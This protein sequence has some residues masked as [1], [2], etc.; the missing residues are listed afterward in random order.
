[1]R[2]NRNGLFLHRTSAT[3]AAD[4]TPDVPTT[5]APARVKF[6]DACRGLAVL[7]ML[8][9]N[10]MN[11]FLRRVPDVLRHNQGD[12][13]RF[14]DFPAPAFQFLIG[15]SLVLYLA[16]RR[17]LGAGPR[18]ARL[19]AVV[20]FGLLMALGIALDGIGTLT[21]S[22]Q[23]GVLQT[24]ALGGIVATVVFEWGDAAVAAL[25]A[26]LLALYSGTLNGDVH[27]EPLAAV[28]FVPLTLAGLLVGRG[29]VAGGEGDGFVGRTLAVAASGLG[30]AAV[31]A[32][33]GVPFNKIRGTSSFVGVA[34]AASA[35]VL[36]ATAAAERR[37]VCA[38]AWLLAIGANALT[39]WVLQYVLVY[40]PAWLLFPTWHRLPLGAGMAASTAA[41]TALTAL[42]IA[43]AR[44]G[45]RIP[46]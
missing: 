14:F 38:P 35:L 20:R 1:M 10:M 19:A 9:A 7:G 34:T 15:V 3:M 44:R 22:P 26:L 11:V 17:R 8:L 41:L 43:L 32:A 4:V 40:Y 37:G 39:A 30:A 18:R 29:L 12:A 23:W 27:H 2:Y 31:A 28:A 5:A 21:A 42:T 33:F 24:L 13:L 25:A 36:L 46:I 16:K 6:L 45:I